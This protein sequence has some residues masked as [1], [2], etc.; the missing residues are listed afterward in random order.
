M[1]QLLS[2]IFVSPGEARLRAGWRLLAHLF[3][4]MLLG[5]LFSVIFGVLLY[6]Q[7]IDNEDTLFLASNLINFLAITLSVYIARGYFDRRPMSDLGLRWNPQAGRDLLLGIAIAA[8]MMG[9]IFVALWLLGM[10]TVASFSW[11]TLG[12]GATFSGLLNYLFLFILVGWNEELL[13]RGYWL[14]NLEQGINRPIAVLLTSLVFAA[15]H[16]ANP[17]SSWISTL[18]LFAAGLFLAYGYTVT[19]RL[20]LPIGLHIGWNFFEGV[21]FGFPVSGLNI[22]RL[23]QTQVNGPFWLTGG[24]FGPEAGLILLPALI[25]GAFLI[26]RLATR[27]D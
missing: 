1:K 24:E 6:F 7:P 27:A 11:Q 2:K 3:I 9:G 19:N 25:F 5:T 8:L 12:W 17:N 18:G 21:V 23:M 10:L 15:L 16:A 22:F 14:Q 26:A 4:L 20:W 13:T